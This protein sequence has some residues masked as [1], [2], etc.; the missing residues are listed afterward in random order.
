MWNASLLLL[1]LLSEL[2]NSKWQQQDSDPQLPI[3][4]WTHNQWPH[5]V[6]IE[7]HTDNHSLYNSIH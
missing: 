1:N 4:K 5:K 7:C 3:C 6:K 2:L